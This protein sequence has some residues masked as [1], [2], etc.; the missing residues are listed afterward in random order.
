MGNP[1][2]LRLPSTSNSTL[3]QNAKVGIDFAGPS[4]PPPCQ[5]IMYEPLS[6]NDFLG[7]KPF[8]GR[9]LPPYFRLFSVALRFKQNRCSFLFPPPLGV[10]F[11]PGAKARY[12][13]EALEKTRGPCLP[14]SFF[15]PLPFSSFAHSSPIL[16]EQV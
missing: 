9:V 5:A 13:I 12:D 4:P 2:S 10:L 8:D 15:P 11:L 1:L 14:F 16:R 7:R 3:S 6:A